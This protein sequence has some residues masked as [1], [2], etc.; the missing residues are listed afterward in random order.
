M[1]EFLS[2]FAAEH[3]VLPFD[4]ALYRA[5]KDRH[6][7]KA[8]I[9]EINGFNSMVFSKCVDINNEQ[10]HLK[11]EHIEAIVS[12]TKD[13]RILESL[14]AA[15][16]NV[17]FYEIPERIANA[18]NFN[19]LANIGSVSKK[20]GVLF[21]GL[22]DSLEDGV[23]TDVELAMLEKHC[24]QLIGAISQLKNLA[25]EKSEADRKEQI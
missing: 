15:H 23:I 13:I 16:G 9:A 12:Y 25:R 5:C 11:P 21:D 6:G 2:N 17:V 24:Q 7:S 18:K 19:F 1:S 3:A 14:A 22:S 20:V 4:V 10:Y 8:A